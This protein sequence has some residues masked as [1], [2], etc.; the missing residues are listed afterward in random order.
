MH[1]GLPPSRPWCMWPVRSQ[2]NEDAL[3]VFQSRF[4]GRLLVRATDCQS[5]G[6]MRPG[7]R[8]LWRGIGGICRR[9]LAGLCRL[10]R[11]LTPT[12]PEEE[13]SFSAEGRV[14]E[15]EKRRSLGVCVNEKKREEKTPTCNSE[16]TL[17]FKKLARFPHVARCYRRDGRQNRGMSVSQT[18][19]GMRWSAS[20][21]D[22]LTSPNILYRVCIREVAERCPGFL[23]VVLFLKVHKSNFKHFVRDWTQQGRVCK[24]LNAWGRTQ[25]SGTYKAIVT[26]LFSV[27][28]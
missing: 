18:A 27:I 12:A 28:D 16:N 5:P 13:F 9:L 19:S 1:E 6:I 4:G 25:H 10:S 20:R 17:A 23:A 2:H 22:E 24:L 11:A 15:K 8:R 14:G 21:W 3:G 7:I 26:I